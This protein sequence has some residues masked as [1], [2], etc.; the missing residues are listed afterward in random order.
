MF[1]NC[2]HKIRFL[3]CLSS[4]TCDTFSNDCTSQNVYETL[5]KKTIARFLHIYMYNIDKETYV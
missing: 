4:F 5:S 1:S 2:G 3:L